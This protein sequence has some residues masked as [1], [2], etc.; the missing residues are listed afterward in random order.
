MSH[1]FSVEQF[2]IVG[3]YNFEVKIREDFL[4]LEPLTYAMGTGLAESLKEFFERCGSKIKLLRGEE[5]VGASA[6]SISRFLKSLSSLLVTT[7][8]GERSF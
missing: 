4:Q 2:N 5:Y 1:E 8:T 6:M 7:S 3:I